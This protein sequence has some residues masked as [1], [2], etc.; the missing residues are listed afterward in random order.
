MNSRG[1]REFLKTLGLGAGAL[2]I[3]G[4]KAAAARPGDRPNILWIVSEDNSPLFGCYGDKFAT[5]PNFDKFA[6]Q[7]TL[8]ENALANTPVCAP[9]R[10]TILTGMYACSMGTHHM[11]S[12]YRIPSF[13]KPY[14]DYLRAAGYWCTNHSKT[15]YNIAMNDRKPWDQCGRGVGYKKRAEGQPFFCIFNLGV[16]HES[17]IHR[18]AKSTKHSQSK[19]PLPPYHPDT[20]EVRHDWAQYYDKIEALDGQVGR[21]LVDLKKDGL[22][23]D[24]IVLY[25]AD[26][27]GVLCRSK[28]FL[29]DTGTHVPMIVRFPKKYRHLAPG[30]P[31][32][33]TDR[34][35]SF[36]DLAPTLLSLAGV[37]V[38]DYIQGEAF[39][40][41]QQKPPREYAYLFRGRMDERFDMMRA[42]RDK[43]YK[44]IRNYMPHRIYGQH[45]DYLWRAP[46]TR[47]WE[48]EFKAG[49]CNE[50]Q[51]I[52]WGK[53]P[54]EELYDFT[55]D[56]WEVNN[57]ADDPRHR[58][59]LERMRA[60]TAKWV[61]DIRDP[62]FMPEGQ[63]IERS[64]GTTSFELVRKAGFPL[65][66]IIE[67]A[68][69]ATMR[70]ASKLPELVRRMGDKD[71]SVRFWA[72]TGCIVLRERARAAAVALRKALA[73]SSADVRIAAGEA[74]CILG[75]V[76]QGLAAIKKELGNSNSK[77]S[78]HAIN[79]LQSLGDVAKPA[80]GAIAAASKKGDGYVKR[81]AKHA[82]QTLGR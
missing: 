3:H 44:Y 18:S 57:L 62:G 49:R 41:K 28:R 75:M 22:A 7:G 32:T 48:E 35:V 54:P 4:R 2:A 19:V 72:A 76:D 23:E 60:A 36:V 40:G 63:M 33:R 47:S 77:I 24:T 73:D 69:I 66:R 61:R 43:R 31:G 78:L 8:Y 14:P 9:A 13:I 74:L 81:A 29:N 27:G 26:H 55:I 71:P 30:A 6:T 42:V 1:R 56:P 12:R 39:L 10:S 82:M 68:E 20:P 11:R 34:I 53:K 65:E 51:S 67:T 38:P 59:T 5:T 15:D 58:A 25:Y 80:A 70:D 16:S 64:E 52:F 45:L 21:I 17:S 50:A 46:A 37:K 79:A